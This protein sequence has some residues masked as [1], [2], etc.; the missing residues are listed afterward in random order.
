MKK[1]EIIE[2]EKRKTEWESWL[3][4]K[5]GAGVFGWVP[6]ENIEDTSKSDSIPD[7]A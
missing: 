6:L 5:N 4:C 2:G 1:D 7:L 3:W